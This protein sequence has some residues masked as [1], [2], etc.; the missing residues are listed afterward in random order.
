MGWLSWLEP[1]PC[2]GG[3][4]QCTLERP[5]WPSGSGRETE[6]GKGEWAVA[7]AGRMGGKSAQERK[8]GRGRGGFG[9]TEGNRPGKL[10][11]I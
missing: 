9:P 10:L 4:R 2:V 1:G 3:R 6:E 11:Q 8:E 7:Q 5:A